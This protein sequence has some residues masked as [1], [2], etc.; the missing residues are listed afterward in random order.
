MRSYR[1]FLSG[2]WEDLAL[3]V[4]EAE[5][6][7]WHHHADGSPTWSHY[8]RLLTWILEL[9]ERMKHYDYTKASGAAKVWL[10]G[11][12]AARDVLDRHSAP[13]PGTER[14]G[15]ARLN[16]ERH[17]P[18]VLAEDVSVPALMISTRLLSSWNFR[19]ARMSISVTSH[20]DMSDGSVVAI[21]RCTRHNHPG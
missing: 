5:N 9:E 2:L 17:Q 6:A 20:C 18:S 7:G 12:S 11:A 8:Q 19:I 1:S 3:G 4:E 16:S 10:R 15:H 21:P 13:D 14:P